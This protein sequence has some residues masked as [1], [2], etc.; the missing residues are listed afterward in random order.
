MPRDLVT[1]GAPGGGAGN[2]RDSGAGRAAL[3]ATGSRTRRAELAIE[4]GRA[5]TGSSMISTTLGVVW[6]L[7]VIYGPRTEATHLLPPEER[8]ITVRIEN[9]PPPPPPPAEEAAPKPKPPEPAPKPDDAALRAQREQRRAVAAAAAFGGSAPTH[10]AVGDVSNVLRG[11]DVVAGA[12]PSPGVASAGKAVLAYGQGGQ[13]SRTPGRT[14]IGDGG[15]GK[16]I[17][18]VGSVGAGAGIGHAGVTISAPRAIEVQ[19]L[20]GPGRDVG[21]LGTAVREREPQL[22]YCYVEYGLKVDPGLAGSVTLALTLSESGGVTS[23]AVTRKTWSGQGAAP[24]ESCVLEK[25]RAWR[26]PASPS[27]AGT[28][29]FSFNFTR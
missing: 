10:G 20:G 28:Y 6:L 23:A 26:F 17:G 15:G 13:G 27:G 21:E 9:P 22:R 18:N 12:A 19:G 24:T 5:L 2:R 4:E 1:A 11:T 16:G 3:E 14:D 29:E 7:F 8:P 25:V